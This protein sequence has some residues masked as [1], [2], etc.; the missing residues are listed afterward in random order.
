M[1]RKLLRTAVAAALA[2]SVAVPAQFALAQGELEEIVVTATRRAQD[3][4]EVPVSIVAITGENLELQGLDSLED[5]GNNIPNINI[6]GGAFTTGTNF[7]VRGLPNVGLYVDGVWQVNTSGFLTQDFVD[8]DRIEVL[9]G[10]QGTTY[11]RDAV[12]GAIRIWTAQPS[13]EFGGN[14]TATT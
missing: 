9:R 5:V 14:I 12:G 7:T 3:L 8:V 4:Q 11:G 2:G 13:D 10:P 6:Q 1:K